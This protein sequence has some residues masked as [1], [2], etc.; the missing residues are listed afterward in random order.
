MIVA[1]R[2]R[3][4]REEFKKLSMTILLRKVQP[5]NQYTTFS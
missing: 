4:M 2:K 3:S 5:L 1:S